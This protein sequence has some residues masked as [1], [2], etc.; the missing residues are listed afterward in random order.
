MGLFNFL[1]A[2]GERIKLAKTFA[3]IYSEEKTL[4]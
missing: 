2:G 1:K 4:S 3:L